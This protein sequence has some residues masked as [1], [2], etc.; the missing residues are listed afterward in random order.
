[1][2]I[3]DLLGDDSA[4]NTCFTYSGVMPAI[5]TSI[6][7]PEKLGRVK[8]KLLN[9]DTSEDETGFIRVMTPMT[10]KQWGMFFFPEV[11]DEVLVAFSGGDVSRPYV[12]G[13]LW[14]QQYKPPAEIKDKK[15]DLRKI[16]TRSGHELTFSDESGKESIEIITP[17]KLTV[18]L[19]DE[20]LVITIKDRES[21]NIV[22]IDSKNGLVTIEGKNKVNVAS[23]NSKIVLDGSA[24][25]VTIESSQSITL[26]SQQ[27][28]IDAKGTLDLKAVGS[29]GISADGPLKA[30]GA[31]IKLN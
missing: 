23:G 30:K 10:G 31:V 17:K 24:N 14:N 9:R 22:K 1:M 4:K 25:S 8:V 19:D 15:N 28:V 7:D 2:S 13:S 29:L 18:K 27:I 16:K 20:K 3:I 12:L 5:V 11:G 26:K 21:D 6:D